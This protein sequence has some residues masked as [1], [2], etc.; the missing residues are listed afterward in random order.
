M[1]ASETLY[2]I[3]STLMECKCKLPDLCVA[4]ASRKHRGCLRLSDTLL[5]VAGTGH[6]FDASMAISLAHGPLEV[7]RWR[8]L[9]VEVRKYV[10][11]HKNRH[12]TMANVHR[13][14]KY[15]ID[16]NVKRV[17]FEGAEC[18]D[19]STVAL[20]KSKPLSHLCDLLAQE[21]GPICSVLL[22]DG[23]Q[24]YDTD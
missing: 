10:P 3:L 7:P 16:S 20:E 11:E 12:L 17:T 1:E 18:D 5:H 22:A 9:R 21:C 14:Q 8:H 13:R 6:H 19:E 23:R 15:T 2:G 24:L 4:S